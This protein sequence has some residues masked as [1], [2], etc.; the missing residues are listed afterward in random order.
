MKIR[1]YRGRFDK[2]R[3][4][5]KFFIIGFGIYA[6]SMLGINTIWGW[7]RSFEQVFEVKNT[8]AI[9]VI[10]SETIQE[11]RIKY[12]I[13]KI[14]Q[15]ARVYGVNGYH[16]ERTIECESRFNNIQST[17]YK[18]G[19]RED[20]WGIAQIHLPSHPE[21]NRDEAL[22]ELFAIEWMAS[23]FNNPYVAWYGYNRKTNQCT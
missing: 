6:I 16:M 15:T 21:V 2:D 7:L 19:V 8:R 20:S 10:T 23:N 17:A 9:E 22:D 18:N 14:Y 3:R 13:D 5:Y 11:T 4:L 12:L 1:D